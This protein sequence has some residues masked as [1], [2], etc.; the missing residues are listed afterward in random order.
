MGA[1]SEYLAPK[2]SFFNIL[3]THP[4][5]GASAHAP[6]A[7]CDACHPRTASHPSPG[8]H[9]RVCVTPRPPAAVPPWGEVQ[10]RLKASEPVP[11]L[12]PVNSRAGAAIAPAQPVSSAPSKKTT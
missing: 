11:L 7:P 5:F 9:S 2:P 3:Y 1:T 4:N 12:P 6:E 10:Q 8:A